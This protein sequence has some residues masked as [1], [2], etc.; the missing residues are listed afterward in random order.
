[1]RVYWDR[2]RSRLKDDHVAEFALLRATLTRMKPRSIELV[3]FNSSGATR[4]VLGNAEAVIARLRTVRYRGATSFAPIARDAAPA[5]RCLLFSDGRPAIDLAATVELRCRLD[6]V[7]GAPTADMAWLRHLAADHGGRAFAPGRNVAG[8]A[9]AIASGA[10]AVA[11]VIDD[12]GRRLPFVP[13]ADSRGGWRLIARAPAVGDVRVRI[14]RAEIR[15]VVPGAGAAFDG[16]GALLASEALALLG[17][18]AARADFVALSRRY[19][20]ASPSL[21]FVVLETPDDYIEADIA[22]PDNYPKELREEYQEDRKDADEEKAEAITDRL[23]EVVD[24]WEAQVA[25]W[26]DH[27]AESSEDGGGAARP[28]PPPAPP[29][30]PP[31]YVAEPSPSAPMAAVDS[32]RADDVAAESNESVVVTG[33][34][35]APR[36]AID[37]WQPGRS[38]LRAFN[39]APAAF[40]RRFPIEEVK[41]GG[42]PAFYLDTAEWLRRHGRGSEAAEMVLSALDLP[43]ANEV[44]LGI[45]ADRL[46]RYG[47]IDRAVELRERQA[48]LDPARPQPKRLLAL[49]LARR[50]ALKPAG[51]RADLE[52]AVALLSDVAL[53]PW[54]EDWDGTDMIALMEANALIPK[55][56]ALGGKITLDPRLIALLDVDLRVVV[57]WTTAS[58]DLDLWVDEPTGER[59]IY[60][61]QRTKIGGHLSDDMTQGYGPEEYLLRKAPAGS[62]L[63]QAN[64][65]ASDAIDPN[66][67]SLITAHLIRDFGR[68]TQREESVDIELKRDEEGAKRIGRIIVSGQEQ[69]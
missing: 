34:R 7:A 19:G 3:T 6:A 57:D 49:A 52:R 50:A 25:W 48:V 16:E 54:E 20:I 17:G 38:Y 69:K 30:P 31:G 56:R 41:G 53:T 26:K 18:T 10:P 9:S 21:S 35:A 67:Q 1:V 39:R 44:T 24:R 63:V 23:D 15:R 59:A 2:S 4:A 58:T 29:P 12:R 32:V 27:T 28:P 37:A 60:N 43:I 61:N 51:A 62:Y 55:L 46:E 5:D 65:Y 13:V 36:I 64:V 14:G 11:A 47:A 68:P 8:V 40:D 45:V 66:G 42:V 22:P 33:L